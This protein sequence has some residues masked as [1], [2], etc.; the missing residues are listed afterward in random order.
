M[1]EA[2]LVQL[3]TLADFRASPES[4]YVERFLARHLDAG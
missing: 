1:A 3:G 2:R 4:P